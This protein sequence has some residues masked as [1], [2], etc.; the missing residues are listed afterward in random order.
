MTISSALANSLSGL[1]ANARRA[2]VA[3]ANIAN[4]LTEGYGR[5]SV[6]LAPTAIGAR[7]Q[8]GVQRASN[9]VILTDRRS[10]DGAAA[11]ADTQARALRTVETAFGS[12]GDPASLS[13]RLVDL[14]LALGAAAGDP[15]SDRLLRGGAQALKDLAGAISQTGDAIQT[16]RQRADTRIHDAVRRL[17]TALGQVETLNAD[18]ERAY[19]T[20][21]DPSA[22]MDQRQVVIDGISELVPVR[23]IAQPNGKV[24]LWTASGAQLLDGRAAR[25]A[26]TPRAVITPDMTQASGALS[27]LTVN[28]IPQ[29]N[30]GVGRLTGGA[31]EADFTLRDETL[32]GQQAALDDIALDLLSRFSDPAVDPTIAPGAP[33][34]LTDNGLAFT[35]GDEVGLAQRLRVNAAIDPAGLGEVWRLRDGLGAAAPGEVG[36]P[37]QLNRT[38]AALSEQRA[39]GPGSTALSAFDRIARASETVSI[40]RLAAEQELI[41]ASARRDSL[42]SAE[43]A[44][45]V[46]T[47]AELQRLLLVEQAYAANA[48]VIQTI[49]QLMQRL[50]EI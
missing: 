23:E 19:G 21:R 35:A 37:S 31:L 29:A 30:G 47:D 20:G 11:G 24:A 14:E 40:D 26:F 46:D 33:G 3:S 15:A 49:D 4:A 2:E 45:G 50:M 13:A 6:E 17:N 36:D 38:I 9:M 5:R 8:G 44:E 7:G 34:L 12:V 48:R 39:T 41:F 16:E 10:S 22:L 28:G 18:I 1:T 27:G 32:T 25:I 43:L 42:R